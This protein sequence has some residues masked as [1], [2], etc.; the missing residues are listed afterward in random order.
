MSKK[1]WFTKEEGKFFAKILAGMLPVK[2]IFGKALKWILPIALNTIDD[3]FGDK[4][5]EPWQTYIENLVTM[6]YT[7]ANGKAMTAKEKEDIKM[8]CVRVM[9][10]G[11]DIPFVDED[12]ETTIF[13][14]AWQF[15]ASIIYKWVDKN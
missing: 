14:K 6:V 7:A 13:M 2:G 4:V 5:P 10:V 11:I 1:G 8:Y 3:K 9:N 15:A 12:A